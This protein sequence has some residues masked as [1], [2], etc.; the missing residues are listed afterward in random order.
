MLTEYHAAVP[1]AELADG[2]ML[3]IEINGEYILLARV[4]GEIHAV[5]DICSHFHTHLSNG[6]LLADR[7]QVQCPLHDSCFDLRTGEPEDPPA[8]DP[9]EVYGVRVEAGMILVG[10]RS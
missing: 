3:G 9:I 4:N 5:N 6:E 7:C 8:E 2:S 10:P 1:D